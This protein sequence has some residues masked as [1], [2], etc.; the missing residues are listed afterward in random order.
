MIVAIGDLVGVSLAVSAN[1]V[2]RATFHSASAGHRA[3]AK[4][5]PFLKIRAGLGVAIFSHKRLY[6]G[7]KYFALF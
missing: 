6:R 4:R 1:A 5:R 3:L 2:A 7:S